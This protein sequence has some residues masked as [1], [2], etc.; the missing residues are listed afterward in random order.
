MTYTQ[1]PLSQIPPP[2]I[3]LFVCLSIISAIGIMGL[4]LVTYSHHK[5]VERPHVQR[6]QQRAFLIA[7][8]IKALKAVIT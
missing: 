1:K 4:A 2:T 7:H 6:F 5:D 8:K 3:R